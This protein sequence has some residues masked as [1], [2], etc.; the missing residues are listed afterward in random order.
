MNGTPS[1]AA[2]AKAGTEYV[3]AEGTDVPA[4]G[5]HNRAR[6]ATSREDRKRKSVA[7]SLES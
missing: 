1:H 4:H 2:N 5:H 7:V 3:A 6:V